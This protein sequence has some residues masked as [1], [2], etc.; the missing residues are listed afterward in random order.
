[1]NAYRLSI[2]SS[3]YVGNSHVSTLTKVINN[4]MLT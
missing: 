2:F 4:S 1:M 3:S